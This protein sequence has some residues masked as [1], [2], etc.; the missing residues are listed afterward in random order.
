MSNEKMCTETL[1]DRRCERT[2]L[3]S[4][5]M[6]R[7]TNENEWLTLPPIYVVN[8]I[9]IS[10]EDVWG[11]RIG[12]WGQLKDI[13]VQPPDNIDLMLGTNTLGAQE[14]LE[15]RHSPRIGDPYA[16]KTRLGWCVV[17]L[18][19]DRKGNRRAVNRVRLNKRE[20]NSLINAAFESGFEGL[21]DDKLGLS[22]EDK[23]WL[24]IV[25][26]GCRRES[27]HYVI[28]LPL[29]EMNMGVSHSR[30]AALRR[31]VGLKRKLVKDIELR[32]HYEDCVNDMIAKG[33]AEK[34]SDG[35][36]GNWYL[37]HFSVRHPSKPEKV[38]VVFDCAAKAGGIALNDLLLQGPDLATQLL[39]V[40]LRFREGEFAFTADVNAMFHQVKVPLEY[41]D[42]LRFFWWEGGVVDG[43]M[44]EYLSLI[45]I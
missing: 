42:F 19:G 38:R 44:C 18:L 41:R 45:H 30:V 39:D 32:E 31:A 25:K 23:R 33:Y 29:R 7:G 11:D 17:G 8:R 27:G 28:P 1:H 21:N 6:V 4:G 3:V 5:L 9:P 15:I 13:V 10:G 16:I 14:P 12:S 2:T 36:G 20:I 26:E 40:L 37:A 24:E 22:G 35:S 34:V 43:V